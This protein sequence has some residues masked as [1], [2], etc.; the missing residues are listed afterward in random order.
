MVNFSAIR[1]LMSI[2]DLVKCNKQRL[3]FV[4]EEYHVHGD[5]LK[6]M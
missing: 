2:Q 3:R 4:Q 6:F 5:Q 1:M